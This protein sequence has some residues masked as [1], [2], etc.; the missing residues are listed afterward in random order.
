MSITGD[1]EKS[2]GMPLLTFLVLAIRRAHTS[3][4]RI[5]THRKLLDLEGLVTQRQDV[6]HLSLSTRR[7]PG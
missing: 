2:E 7:N 3:E 6:C 1:S 5:N 4:L